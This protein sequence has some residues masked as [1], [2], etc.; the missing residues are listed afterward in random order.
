MKNAEG[1][2]FMKKKAPNTSFKNGNQK[3]QENNNNG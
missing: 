2:K 1:F 3:E